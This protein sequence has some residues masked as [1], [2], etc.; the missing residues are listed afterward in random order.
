MSPQVVG[1]VDV[2]ESGSH[3]TNN[4]SQRKGNVGWPHLG[5]DD[6]TQKKRD[7]ESR[8]NSD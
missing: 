3:H 6:I 2:D 5:V 7:T 4:R 8:A 1:G